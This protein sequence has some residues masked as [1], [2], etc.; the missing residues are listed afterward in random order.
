MLRRI[1]L[2]TTLLVA[3]SRNVGAQNYFEWNVSNFVATPGAVTATL[4]FRNSQTDALDG[5]VWDISRVFVTLGGGGASGG[6]GTPATFGAVN[7]GPLW[8]G[9]TLS[10][11]GGFFDNPEVG[12]GGAL[13]FGPAQVG[14]TDGGIGLLGCVV[15]ILPAPPNPLSMTN[16]YA[17]Q[18]CSAGGFDG[19]AT[20]DLNFYNISGTG[21]QNRSLS[22]L[23]VRG[24]LS[25]RT[26]E[27]YVVPEPTSALLVGAGL[28]VLAVFAKRLEHL[29]AL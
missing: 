18:T 2:C 7:T 17:G 16:S 1:A 19:W 15:P 20:I 13:A 22:D 29:Q 9:K 27:N 25:S 11:W 23:T 24:S 12:S 26:I 14:W 10:Y 5:K 8:A 3:A 28:I 21:L 6:D 4:R